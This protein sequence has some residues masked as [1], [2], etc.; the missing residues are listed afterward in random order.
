MLNIDTA[1]INLNNIINNPKVITILE[2]NFDILN[3]NICKR[4][5]VSDIKNIIQV[6]LFAFFDDVA[7]NTN[8]PI[9]N[10]EALEYLDALVGLCIFNKINTRLH[11]SNDEVSTF[12]LLAVNENLSN[13]SEVAD[14]VKTYAKVADT[15]HITGSL[16]P[17]TEK[18]TLVKKF[19]YSFVGFL[20]LT[21]T[22]KQTLLSCKTT[23][24]GT[25]YRVTLVSIYDICI[26]IDNLDLFIY[27]ARKML[28]HYYLNA[29]KYKGYLDALLAIDYKVITLNSDRN[30]LRILNE[31]NDIVK[32]LIESTL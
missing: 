6:P 11:E 10:L 22:Q 8:V 29:L 23:N 4:F 9:K 16:D 14:C 21:Q 30:A 7:S 20:S 3:N 26:A 32:G 5:L 1:K 27:I 17:M 2:D 18:G 31:Q 19:I 15:L 25:I 12:T 13:N 28:K 24:V